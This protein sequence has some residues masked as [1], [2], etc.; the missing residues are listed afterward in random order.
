[1]ARL[2]DRRRQLLVAA[3][4]TRAEIH[5][6][7]DDRCTGAMKLTYDFGMIAPRPGP[8]AQ[9]GQ[10]SSVDLD[11]RG[12]AARWAAQEFRTP[13]CKSI[14]NRA[15]HAG[16]G[17]KDRRRRNQDGEDK[18][19]WPAAPVAMWRHNRLDLPPQP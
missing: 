19:Q 12:V 13:G 14:F 1:M 16:G 6:E 8:A 4:G 3:F 2:P 7:R 17:Q 9:L 5:V 10:A 18:A 11:D 15:E